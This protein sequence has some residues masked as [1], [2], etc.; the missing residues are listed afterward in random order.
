MF[1]SS[2][3][4]NLSR[5]KILTVNWT[6]AGG[7]V[8]AVRL[9]GDRHSLRHTY[10]LLPS[11]SHLEDRD[12]LKSSRTYGQSVLTSLAF[13]PRITRQDLRVPRKPLRLKPHNPPANLSS[14][15]GYCVLG[16]LL[17]VQDRLFYPACAVAA[18]LRQ[19]TY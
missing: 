11:A 2:L 6:P 15:G 14:L 7:V 4:T 12:G 9:E 18:T 3:S 1:R 16:F 8:A 17:M 5:L 19:S 10:T 13:A